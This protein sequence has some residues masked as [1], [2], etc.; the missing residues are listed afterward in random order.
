MH[1]L[2]E[3]Y[4]CYD[5][6]SLREYIEKHLST[7]NK[8]VSCGYTKDGEPHARTGITVTAGH[9]TPYFVI[10][11]EFKKKSSIGGKKGEYINGHI[12]CDGKRGEHWGGTFEEDA[13]LEMNLDEMCD[14][15]RDTSEQLEEAR[16]RKS[17][18]KRLNESEKYL[19]A[20]VVENICDKMNEYVDENK[21]EY[22]SDLEWLS[23]LSQDLFDNVVEFLFSDEGFIDDALDDIRDAMDVIKDNAGNDDGAFD[24]YNDLNEV[25]EHTYA[26]D[27]PI[28]EHLSNTK[29]KRL[30]E[31]VVN[32]HE[33]FMKGDY[34]EQLAREIA[35]FVQ[36]YDEDSDDG[37]WFVCTEDEDL[38]ENGQSEGWFLGD[39]SIH[40]DLPIMYINATDEYL[41][42]NG[43]DID[44]ETWHTH[45]IASVMFLNGEYYAFGMDQI[46][47]DEE[48]EKH[49][50]HF[51]NG[52]DLDEF[53]A[54]FQA[55]LGEWWECCS[56]WSREKK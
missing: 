4:T 9:G 54:D 22:G 29:N 38:D 13:S 12:S 49:L 25:L 20:D 27:K 41:E 53:K 34:S 26:K 23:D 7:R 11:I 21:G 24:F 28:K 2:I 36:N 31:R 45:P 10:G 1:K 32:E 37:P 15:I 56:E 33:F 5:T 8:I 35:D 6:K 19:L 50:R 51:Y 52:N 40:S 17:R 43:A 3:S 46:G 44:D 47:D 39:A 48:A 16:K 14:F 42:R 55:L 18:N 30:N